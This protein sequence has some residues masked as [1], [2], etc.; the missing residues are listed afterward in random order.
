MYVDLAVHLL[1]TNIRKYLPLEVA[2][3]KSDM[4]ILDD[5]HH[6]HTLALI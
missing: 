1:I 3:Q 4:H 6:T 2:D 5:V